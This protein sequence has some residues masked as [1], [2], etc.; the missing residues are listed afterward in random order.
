MFLIWRLT[1]EYRGYPVKA[2]TVE[3]ERP[4]TVQYEDFPEP[5]VHEGSILVE[6]MTVGVCGTDVE[7]LEGKYGWARSGKTR[8]SD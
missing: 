2:I 7:I 6:A 3:P 1:D 8:S 4:G 5:D